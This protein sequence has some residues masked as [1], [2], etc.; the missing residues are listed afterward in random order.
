MQLRDSVAIVTGASRGIGVHIADA[1]ARRG[2]HLALAARS[3]GD[4]EAVAERLRERGVRV[5]PVVTDVTDR[6]SIENLVETTTAELGPVDI[7]VNNAGLELAGYSHQLDPDEIDRVVSV[8]LTSVIQLSRMVLPSMLD[9]RH[10]HICN[11]AS[12][13]G[14]VARPYATVYS[15][16]KH[17]VVGFS[18][19]LRAEMASEGVEV[20]V[21]CPSYISDVGMFADR[22]AG[23][24]AADP[25]SSLKLVSATKVAEETVTSIEKN[26]AQVVVGPPMVK[27]AGAVHAAS[28]DTAIGI[29]R[30][31]GVLR[32]L[33]KEA[34]GD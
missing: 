27:V 16:T 18:W 8:N 29:A 26:R 21:V 14:M 17:G 28:P 3:E 24:D 31:S 13:A 12:A 30:R 23:M 4:L 9:R 11:I 1:L 20:S 19:S 2:S 10:G 15:A 33:K 34:T 22:V 25:P 32:F 6:A 5:T 7:L